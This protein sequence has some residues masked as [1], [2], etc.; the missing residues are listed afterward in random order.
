M[1]L[2]ILTLLIKYKNNMLFLDLSDDRYI[3]HLLT[4][5][6]LLIMT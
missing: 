6:G 4:Y 2:R 5:F 3:D 1:R